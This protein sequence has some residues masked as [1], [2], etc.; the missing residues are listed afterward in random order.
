MVVFEGEIYDF[1]ALVAAI[2]AVI[3]FVAGYLPSKYK[4]FFS[5]TAASIALIITALV[6]YTMGNQIDKL[7]VSGA[8]AAVAVALVTYLGPPRD[9]EEPK[10]VT[11]AAPGT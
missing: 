1:N 3:V 2:V 4:S 7:A 8:I 11:E 10:V 5:A 6:S 9:A